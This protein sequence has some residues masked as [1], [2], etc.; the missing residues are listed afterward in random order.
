MRTS[1]LCFVLGCTV[2]LSAAPIWANGDD[3]AIQSQ[4]QT[5]RYLVKQGKRLFQ[6]FCAHCHGIHGDGD[7]YNAE[8]LDKEPAELSHPKFQR[9]KTNHQ[10]FRVIHKGGAGVRK[11]HLMPP[12]GSTLSQAEIWAL[13][14]YIR[15]LATENN[16]P[17]NLPQGVDTE[18]P[19]HEAVSEEQLK[20]FSEWLAKAESD[21]EILK[22]G[23]KLFKKKKSCFACHRVGE[24]GGKVGPE[25]TRAGF[26]YSPEW[27]YA[28][29]THPQA[30]KTETRMPDLSLETED[31]RAIAAYLNSLLPEEEPVPEDWQPYLNTPGDAERGR[32][33]FFDPDGTVYCSKCHRVDG[34]GGEIGPDLSHIGSSRTPGFLLESLLDPKAVITAGYATVLILTKERKFI[35][36]IKLLEDDQ[37]LDIIDKEGNELYIRKADIKKF[38]TQKISMMPGNFV[39]LLEVQDVADLLAYLKSLTLKEFASDS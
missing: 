9:K 4:K 6:K 32:E 3:A 5:P 14:A 13:V 17:V 2:F 33:M 11:S 39:D 10:I 31:A 24:E 20:A 28:W 36:G 1:L 27:V 21:A 30:Y 15:S 29:V 16:H 34:K 19:R 35:T 7:G 22:R 38:K 18:R 26:Y 25:L 23:E 12:F 8:Y 37:G